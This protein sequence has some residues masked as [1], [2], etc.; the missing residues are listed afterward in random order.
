MSRG[1]I[2]SLSG[3]A[4]LVR[5]LSCWLETRRCLGLLASLRLRGSSAL[6]SLRIQALK[7]R[8]LLSWRLSSLLGHVEQQQ[9]LSSRLVSAQEVNLDELRR[10]LVSFVLRLWVVGMSARKRLH[11]SLCQLQERKQRHLLAVLLEDWQRQARVSCSSSEASRDL[12]KEEEEELEEQQQQQQ[13]RTTIG[14]KLRGCKVED[15][16]KGG[17][18]DLSGMFFRGDNLIAAEGCMLTDDNVLQVLRGSDV[19][20]TFV[21]ILLEKSHTGEII[22]VRLK[23][24]LHAIHFS[25]R[26]RDELRAKEETI[27]ASA[28]RLRDMEAKL[29]EKEANEIRMEE[30]IQSLLRKLNGEAGSEDG[31][32]QNRRELLGRQEMQDASTCTH[33]DP[34]DDETRRI[35][36]KVL[37]SLRSLPAHLSSVAGRMH[38]T[39]MQGDDACADMQEEEATLED[40]DVNTIVGRLLEAVETVRGEVTKRVGEVVRELRGMEEKTSQM[41][42]DRHHLILDR[43]RMRR[44]SEEIEIEM[45]RKVAEAE[46]AREMAERG[47]EAAENERTRG[48]GSRGDASEQVAPEPHQT[49]LEEET[50]ETL[51]YRRGG[52]TRLKDMLLL[53]SSSKPNSAGYRGEDLRNTLSVIRKI[54]VDKGLCDAMPGIAGPEASLPLAE[55][56]YLWFGSNAEASRLSSH[57]RTRADAECFKFLESLVRLQQEH[58]EVANFHYLLNSCTS[59]EV[60]YY[61]LARKVLLGASVSARTWLEVSKPV[62]A[63]ACDLLIMRHAENSYAETVREE[64]KREILREADQTSE[65]LEPFAFL[66]SLLMLY[67]E[68]KKEVRKMLKLLFDAGKGM[69][70]FSELHKLRGMLQS[71]EPEVQ[72]EEVVQVY[73]HVRSLMEEDEGQ[74][75]SF[76]KLWLVV[77]R[78]GLL[79]RRQL[80]G[81]RSE[82]DISLLPRL[83]R[84]SASVAS[85]WSAVKPHV[86]SMVLKLRK[87]NLAIERRWGRMGEEQVKQLEQLEGTERE[88]SHLVDNLRRLLANLILWHSMQKEIHADRAV[89]TADAELHNLALLV[90]HRSRMDE[91]S[92]SFVANYLGEPPPDPDSHFPD[93]STAPLT[94]VKLAPR[95]RTSMY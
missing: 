71:I 28:Q 23:R 66:G 11:V 26:L 19:P 2:S 80:I 37:T 59:D 56:V 81:V 33:E 44:K 87:S 69:R 38:V 95:S 53:P 30:T 51:G 93:I 36:K 94:P 75:I 70:H 86:H 15:V 34:P 52:L 82:P 45:Q 68:E 12:D 48:R 49:E 42:Q 10:C 79:I 16:A 43:D 57:P 39:E 89:T 17:P 46:S 31:D 13:Q 76:H 8:A 64:M 84:K 41:E 78:C 27:L 77:E 7:G 25:H 4:R 24:E 92:S 9:Q 74:P 1:I 58:P 88:G 21:S 5:V 47:R 54:S 90:M 40:F 67:K 14:L 29:E 73:Q 91:R 65:T 61:M 35:L 55:F 6:L 83:K 85:T 20:G 63:Q 3:V 32:Q 50:E 22:H 72:D 18:A 62:V 60:A